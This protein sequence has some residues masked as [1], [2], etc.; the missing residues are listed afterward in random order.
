MG[1]HLHRFIWIV[2]AVALAICVLVTAILAPETK[3][4][5]LEELDKRDL[6]RAVAHSG[7]SVV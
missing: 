5:T 7:R 1:M 2:F 4:K 6:G 3:G